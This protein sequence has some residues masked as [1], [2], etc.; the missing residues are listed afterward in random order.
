MIPG[1]FY[2]RES[3]SAW[4][5]M[6]FYVDENGDVQYDYYRGGDRNGGAGSMA[7]MCCPR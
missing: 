7:T 4:M 5:Y 1:T 2:Y 3:I 6:T